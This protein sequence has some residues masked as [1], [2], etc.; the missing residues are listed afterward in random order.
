[1]VS[2]SSPPSPSMVGMMMVT[3]CDLSVGFSGM[4]MGRKVQNANRLTIRRV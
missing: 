1:M 3:S 2:R 4:G